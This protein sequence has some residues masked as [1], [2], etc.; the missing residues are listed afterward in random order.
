VYIYLEIRVVLPGL[1][2]LYGEDQEHRQY[3]MHLGVFLEAMEANFPYCLSPN[4]EG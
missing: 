1:A 4:H 2:F 3:I